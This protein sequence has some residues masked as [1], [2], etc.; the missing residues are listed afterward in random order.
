VCP[1]KGYGLPQHLRITIGTPAQ[2]ERLIA[3][4]HQALQES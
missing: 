2:N 1:V 4:L 3:A